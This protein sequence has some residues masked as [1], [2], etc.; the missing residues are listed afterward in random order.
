M[1]TLNTSEKE[2]LQRLLNTPWFKIMK[3]LVK[4]YEFDVLK[5]YRNLIATNGGFT[6][7]LKDQLVQKENHLRGIEQF[8]A[9]IEGKSKGI[10][11]I[12]PKT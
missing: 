11:K 5:G 1:K 6:E 4:E 10:W 8:I 12:E 7:T 9:V 2:Q 3:E